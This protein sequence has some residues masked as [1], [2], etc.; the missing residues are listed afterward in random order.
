MSEL[1]R[2]LPHP[3]P[4]DR[5]P[6]GLGAVVQRTVAGGELPALVVVHDADNDWLIGDG[7]N[8]PNSY[9]ASGLFHLSHIVDL[10]PSIAATATLPLGHIA[11]RNSPDEAWIVETFAYEEEE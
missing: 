4:G 8:D 9:E 1:L 7:I 5:F 11:W 6:E 10:D 2:D 3:F